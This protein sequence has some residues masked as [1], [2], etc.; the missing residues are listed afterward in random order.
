[1]PRLEPIFSPLFLHC[2]CAVSWLSGFTFQYSF[3]SHHAASNLA[4]SRVRIRAVGVATRLLPFFVHG[5]P[6]PAQQ[7]ATCAAR[8]FSPFSSPHF[9]SFPLVVVALDHAEWPQISLSRDFPSLSFFWVR[10]LSNAPLPQIGSPLE[11]LFVPSNCLVPDCLLGPSSFP[12]PNY[13]LQAPPPWF[14]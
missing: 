1:V 4:K 12:L 2:P 10:G 9:L 13:P 6:V 11:T 7:T 5:F 8:P 3:Y 14:N